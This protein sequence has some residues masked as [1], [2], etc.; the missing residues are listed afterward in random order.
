MTKQQRAALAAAILAM[1]AAENL[2]G[3]IDQTLT[4][5]ENKALVAAALGIS[6]AVTPVLDRFAPIARAAARRRAHPMV[7]DGTAPAEA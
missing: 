2:M 3:S 7:D 5:A 4:K 1:K 6:K